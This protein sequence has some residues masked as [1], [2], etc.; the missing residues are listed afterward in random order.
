LQNVK[1][2][3]DLLV[4]GIVKLDKDLDA[5]YQ[6]RVTARLEHEAKVLRAFEDK[7]TALEVVPMITTPSPPP[8]PTPVDATLAVAT[9]VPEEQQPPVAGSIASLDELH[10]T[11]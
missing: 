5:K 1:A 4:D 11:R 9:A 10:A 6:E 7:I 8:A 2:Q 3:L